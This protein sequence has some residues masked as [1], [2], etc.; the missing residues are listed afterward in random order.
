MTQ[1][2]QQATG[3]SIST[4]VAV[5]AGET[6]KEKDKASHA[7][8]GKTAQS[9]RVAQQWLICEMRKIHWTLILKD[10]TSKS[11]TVLFSNSIPAIVFDHVGQLNDVL[12]FL[13]LLT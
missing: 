12:A 3:I 6:R 8:L 10:G 2:A 4:S 9:E 7:I 11:Q 1:A 13:V 5:V